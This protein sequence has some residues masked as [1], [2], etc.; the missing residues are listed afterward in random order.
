MADRSSRDFR[1]G[2][3]GRSR[4]TKA[5]IEDDMRARRDYDA[6]V[7]ERRRNQ[8]SGGGFSAPSIPGD[9]IAGAFMLFVYL[10]LRFAFWL[11]FRRWFWLSIAG[12]T[13]LTLALASPEIPG[14]LRDFQRRQAFGALTDESFTQSARLR[15]SQHQHSQYTGDVGRIVEIDCTLALA[16]YRDEGHFVRQGEGCFEHAGDAGFLRLRNDPPVFLR[17][18]TNEDGAEQLAWRRLTDNGAVELRGGVEFTLDQDG[19]YVADRSN[20]ANPDWTRPVTPARIVNGTI[21][22][23]PFPLPEHIQVWRLEVDVSD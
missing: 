10:P 7:E 3:E 13:V 12:F 9:P 14:M 22:R 23:E 1:D 20:P 17:R 6:G 18:E 21:V 11:L 8:S 5:T 19:G 2:A 16:P 15:V 4:R